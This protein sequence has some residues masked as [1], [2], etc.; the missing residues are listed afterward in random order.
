MDAGSCAA[1][2]GVFSVRQQSGSD[3][4]LHQPANRTQPRFGARQLEG[5][6]VSCSANS[7]L[8]Q[9][10]VFA[11]PND[12]SDATNVCGLAS[13]RV[14]LS[15]MM[16]GDT[17]RRAAGEWGYDEST[18]PKN[19]LCALTLATTGTVHCHAL[20]ECDRTEKRRSV[21]HDGLPAGARVLA[22][23]ADYE[24]EHVK[25]HRCC[26][27]ALDNGVEKKGTQVCLSNRYPT[28]GSAVLPSLRHRDN[29][30]PFSTRSI[31]SIL[32]ERSCSA[33]KG[34]DNDDNDDV[35]AS[36]VEMEVKRLLRFCQ[37]SQLPT[38]PITLWELRARSSAASVVSSRNVDAADVPNISSARSSADANVL[39][40]ARQ[41]NHDGAENI[42]RYNDGDNDSDSDTDDGYL[43]ISSVEENRRFANLLH[44]SSDG[45]TL[46]INNVKGE[47]VDKGTSALDTNLRIPVEYS[48]I[49]YDKLPNVRTAPAC[50][51]TA[52]QH[53]IFDDKQV[54]SMPENRTDLSL[55][56]ISTLEGMYWGDQGGVVKNDDEG[57]F[58]TAE[59]S[60][61]DSVATM[62][63]RTGLAINFVRNTSSQSLQANVKSRKL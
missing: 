27:G 17:R 5:G 18:M 34:D 54:S 11:L 39:Y 53:S 60:Q 29:M 25:D 40:V 9:N 1:F 23:P 63:D 45:I 13:H 16:D 56:M 33:N 44:H 61:Q 22:L 20:L 38:H 43:R 28:P 3:L 32:S 55:A 36:N 51:D 58:Q 4:V 2:D 49:V 57:V 47:N 7:I 46:D 15:K 10:A 26:L 62:D 35:D 41:M 14:P 48:T 59:L 42:R 31:A 19:V 37:G 8:A 6:V 50:N 30:R 12:Y 21:R 24:C 52:T